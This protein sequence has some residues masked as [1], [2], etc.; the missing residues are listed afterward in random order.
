[1]PKI[2][3]TDSGLG[4]LSIAAEYYEW[5]KATPDL[6]AKLIFVNALP[7]AGK[8]YNTMPTRQRKIEIFN[9]FLYGTHTKFRPDLMAIACNTLSVL[10]PATDYYL[11]YPS[12]IMEIV[13]TGLKPF[14]QT[15]HPHPE[16]TIIIFGTRTT[17]DSQSHYKYLVKAGLPADSI[18]A[19]SCPQLAAEIEKDPHSSQTLQIIE[20]SVSEALSRLKSIR[21]KTYVYLACTHYGYVAQK[22]AEVFRTKNIPNVEVVNPNQNMI[23][24]LQDD[25][26]SRE[27]SGREDRRERLSI[28]VVSKAHIIPQELRS[29]NRLIHPLSED[30]AAALKNYQRQPDLF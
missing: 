20:K 2:V 21:R 17:I 5:I 18:I 1:M 4:G 10:A 29:I 14:L 16:S 22:F 23:R 6:Y 25:L 11:R 3:I 28:K 15:Y 7:A 24:A 12:K 8:G 9:R 30:T 27:R 19:Q 26:Q 13:E